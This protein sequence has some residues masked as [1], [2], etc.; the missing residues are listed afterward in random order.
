MPPRSTKLAAFFNNDDEDFTFSQKTVDEAKLSARLR[1]SKRE[2]EQE[3]AEAKR[4]E[5]E[6][7]TK[8]AYAEFVEAFDG[9]GPSRKAA[10]NAFV[11]AGERPPQAPS[12]K[13]IPTGPSAGRRLPSMSPPPLAPPKP[14]GKRAMDKFLEEIKRDQ[15]EREARFSRGSGQGRSSATAMAAYEGQS[16]SKDRGD[17]LTSNLFVA[18]IPPHATEPSLG[19]LFAKAGPVGSVK[20][21]WPRN[22]PT[23][24]AAGIRQL[25]GNSLS[26]FVAFMKRKDAED[27]LR[28]FDGYDWGGSTLRVGWSKAVPVA[29]RPLSVSTL[30]SD[31]PSRRSRSPRDHHSRSR[32]LSSERSH[33]PR[34]SGADAHG[35]AL[36]P[37]YARESSP[38]LGDEIVTDSFIRAV[39]A[40][41]KGHGAD[42]EANLKEREKNNT[43][44]AFMTNRGH[45][46]HAFY[47]GLVESERTL[48][49]EFDDDGYNSVYSTDSA[50]ESERERTRKGALGKLAA[51]RFSAMLRAMS[52]KRGEI[53]RCMAF[54]LE[55][56][57]AAHEVAEL[58]VASLLVEGTPVPRKVARLHLICDILHN[59]AAS[60]PSA[61][62]YRGEFQGRLGVVFDHLANIYHSFPGKITAETF[63]NQITAVIDVWDDWIMFPQDFTQELRQRL[64][65]QVR[66]DQHV[67]DEV[68]EESAEAQTLPAKF[69]ASAFQP[70]TVPVDATADHGVD[71]DLDGA[72]IE[73]HVD[74]VPMDIHSSAA[75]DVDGEPIADDVDGAPI[76]DNLDG[77]PVA[78]DIDGEPVDDIDGEPVADDIDG[79]P[80]AEDV[81]GEPVADDIDGEL[82]AAPIGDD[83]DGELMMNTEGV[84]QPEELSDG[85]PMDESD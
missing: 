24:G 84:R 53:A 42:Y 21:M 23:F 19:Q 27:A 77:D 80:V 59:S 64:E 30:T 48:E 74:G 40:E 65:G 62:K 26:G 61:W 43:K 54:A 25:K 69:K 3:A 10:T 50:E 57:E 16:G 15:A 9:P 29:P 28:Q 12:E 58:I 32:S 46:R 37:R 47:R 20:I 5:E 81:D 35:R 22:D 76:E 66:P 7:N 45:R 83:L 31:K 44:Y 68:V 18:N 1:K 67:E 82:M 8:K 36:S 13:P 55:H 75:D 79:E 34:R 70:A 11:R 49:P 33:S 63:K 6:E 51:K 4:K 52:G 14:K 38:V 71:D 60:V 72:P 78:D 85:E 41:V 17:P 56:A 73:D 39:A 2:K